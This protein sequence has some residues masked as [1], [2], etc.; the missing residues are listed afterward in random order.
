MVVS[1]SEKILLLGVT[2]LHLLRETL[3]ARDVT[4]SL[5]LRGERNVFSYL[6]KRN[7]IAKISPGPRPSWAP[8]TSPGRCEPLPRS[9]PFAP[10]AIF[11]IIGILFTT[12]RT[13]R[14]FERVAQKQFCKVA[15]F[16][17][18]GDWR[19]CPSEKKSPKRGRTSIFCPFSLFHPLIFA[20]YD[21]FSQICP[22][23]KSARF[24]QKFVWTVKGHFFRVCTYHIEH[25]KNKH[26]SFT[27]HSQKN[28]LFYSIIVILDQVSSK[29]LQEMCFNIVSSQM[30]CFATQRDE[31]WVLCEESAESVLPEKQGKAERR[32]DFAW[33][34]QVLSVSHQPMFCKRFT[35]LLLMGPSFVSYFNHG[36]CCIF[37]ELFLPSRLPSYSMFCIRI[38]A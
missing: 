28:D 21:I 26:K 12:T 32:D 30:L 16:H 6:L 14:R 36:F 10:K 35:S 1:L 38:L 13:L 15:I 5:S 37:I 31:C 11:V 27:V 9:G 24:L 8:P 33:K 29:I 7:K 22:R 25:N 19:R 3:Q 4:N 17:N 18:A 2:Q 20:S 23:K 34:R